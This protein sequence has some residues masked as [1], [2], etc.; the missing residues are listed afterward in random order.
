M[1]VGGGGGQ[2]YDHPPIHEHGAHHR[3]LSTVKLSKCQFPCG[4][5]KVCLVRIHILELG[6]SDGE[7]HAQS[8]TRSETHKGSHDHLLA[9]ST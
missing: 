2:L 3:S 8:A 6:C 7:P 1:G 9:D 4:A 5:G